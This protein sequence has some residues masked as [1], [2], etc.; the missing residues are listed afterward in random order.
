MVP[1]EGITIFGN[2]APEESERLRQ[3]VKHCRFAAGQ[4]IFRE[5]DAGDGVYLVGAGRV[6]ISG[7]IN[8]D[9]RRV[10]SKIGPG[11]IFG[12]MAVLDDKPRS[13]SAVAAVDSEIYFIPRDEMLTLVEQ[14]PR[15]AHELLK[16]ISSRLREF[17]QQYIREVLQAERLTVI[18]RFARSII[19]D[20]KNP[21]N[22]ISLSAEMAAMKQADGETRARAN[23]YIRQQVERITDMVNEILEFTQGGQVVL[24]LAPTDYPTYTEEVV[25]EITDEIGIKSVTIELENR[26]P[27]VRLMINPRR[28][29]HVFHNLI[30]NAV[31]AMPKGGNIAIRFLD[32]DKE[33]VTEI[34]DGGEGIAPEI[35]DKLFEAFATHGK[36]HGTGLGLSICKKIIE[37]HHGWISARNKPG[38][39]AVFSF[40]LPLSR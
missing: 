24:P 27:D 34:E 33:V 28:L 23:K 40:G 18:G 25:K 30:H 3:A 11:D 1:L 9:T 31:Q 17:N 2:I 38:G 21:L 36:E 5:G 7:I 4:E 35:A 8:R 16:K 13:A 15:L 39:G 14:S 19:H 26:P 10:F 20:L 12:E 29:R 6:E 37:D 22:I 32:Q